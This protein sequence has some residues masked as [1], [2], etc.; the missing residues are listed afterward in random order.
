[1]IQLICS[2]LALQPSSENHERAS[3]TETFPEVLR[4]AQDDGRGNYAVGQRY[5]LLTVFFTRPCKSCGSGA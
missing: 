5:K 1:M 3:E 4:F 2:L